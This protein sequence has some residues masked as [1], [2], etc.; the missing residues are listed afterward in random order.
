MEGE[1]FKFAGYR[2]R[3][4]IEDDLLLAARWTAAD[5]FHKDGTPP[6]FWIE[7][8]AY[9]ECY[10]LEDGRGPLFFFRIDQISDSLRER[11]ALHIQFAPKETE[12]HAE[13]TRT[14][15]TVGMEWLEG[16]LSQ[17]SIREIFF[18]T[19]NEKLLRFAVKRLDF[20]VDAET[21]ATGERRLR[22]AIGAL[23]GS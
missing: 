7:H 12:D 17:T 16:M 11:A 1:G 4:A 6:E 20:E 3:P 10:L 14:G 9:T 13:R 8:R 5:P 15:L 18:D 23:K 2:L 21:T 22:K 19:R